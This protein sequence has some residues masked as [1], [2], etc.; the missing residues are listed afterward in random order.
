M[1]DLLNEVKS[2]ENRLRCYHEGTYGRSTVKMHV[3]LKKIDTIKEMLKQRQETASA[4]DTIVNG[5]E[6]ID[7]DNPPEPDA[8]KLYLA[9]IGNSFEVVR[10]TEWGWHYG[11]RNTQDSVYGVEKYI[12]LI[13]Q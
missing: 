7:A 10:Y 9:V 4:V 13:R 3:E 1:E 5:T 11:T 8:N 12:P 2:L 6:L